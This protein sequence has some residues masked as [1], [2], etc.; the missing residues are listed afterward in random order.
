MR[1]G[2]PI[3]LGYFAVSFALGIAAKQTGLNALQAGLMSIGMVASAG[4]FAAL[5]LIASAAG[6]IEMIATCI[7]VNMRYFLMS[8]S[9]SQ[10]LSPKTPFIHRFFI[11]HAVTDELFGISS[12]YPG[13]LD[14]VYTYG[15]AIVSWT[16]WTAGTVIGVLAGSILP[17]F[18]V[19]ALG[20]SLYGMFLAI[21]IPPA[22]QN[23]FIGGLVLVS[24]A[25]SGLF[26]IMPYLKDIS[27]GFRIIIL[28]LLLSAA[29]ALLRPL[30][31]PENADT[32][33]DAGSA[34]ARTAD[35]REDPHA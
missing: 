22:K 29:A 20:A 18:L 35:G 28:T 33:A 27:S 26:A 19:A 23:R 13:S 24:M 30:K 1:H 3:G 21:I 4:E 7:V 16:G 31:D 14:P 11:A 10:K 34:N 9:L 15:A 5:S 12:A 6:V 25:A 2:V 8:C 32:G 17:D